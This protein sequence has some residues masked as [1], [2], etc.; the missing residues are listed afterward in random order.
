MDK[1]II[2]DTFKIMLIGDNSS[3]KVELL[4][5]YTNT[6]SHSHHLSKCGV[7][8]KNKT[9]KID[10]LNI[11][12]NIYNIA[13]QDFFR[14]ITYQSLKGTNGL[15]LIYDIDNRESFYRIERHW[16]IKYQ[17]MPDINFILIGNKVNSMT[18]R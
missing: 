1:S 9:I 7:D 18:E 10:G 15:I 4:N 16:M 8:L 17:R 14:N 6:S 3:G 2:D 13:N 12:L 11:Q 5:T